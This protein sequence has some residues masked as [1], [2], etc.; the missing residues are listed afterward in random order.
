MTLALNAP[1]ESAMKV[2]LPLVIASCL[3][4]SACGGV[5]SA[6][7]RNPIARVVFE[8]SSG[9]VT[10]MAVTRKGRDLA[11]ETDPCKAGAGTWCTFTNSATEQAADFELDTNQTAFI[12]WLVNTSGT[13]ETGTLKIYLDGDLRFNKPKTILAGET[14]NAAEIN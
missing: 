14:F 5:T 4:L 2:C 13:D 3:A 11:T 6:S 10:T 8:T 7:S 12:V 9:N 1:G